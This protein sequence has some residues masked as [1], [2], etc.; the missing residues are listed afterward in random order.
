MRVAVFGGSFNPP[1]VGHA[2]VACWARW[3]DVVD[4]VWLLPC[5]AHPFGKPLA[6]FADR[7]A[8][9]DALAGALG[10]WVR[11]ETIEATLPVPSFTLST[12]RALAALHPRHELRLLAGAD[13]L[14]DAPKW[15][16]WEE[17]VRDFRPL[18]VGR[19]ESRLDD[20]A[21]PDVSSSL[22]RDAIRSGRSARH[23]VPAAVLPL[24]LR[25]YAP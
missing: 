24:A 4:A 10:P 18:V 3:T 11:V 13:T 6:A 9:C 16:G 23:L 12:L 17:I 20:I 8:M 7:V 5:F 15:H 21:F 14:R 25:L 2:M 22:V 1:H 19:G